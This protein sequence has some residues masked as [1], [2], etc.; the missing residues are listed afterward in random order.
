[1]F[2]PQTPKSTIIQKNIATRK[3]NNIF[4]FKYCLLV[5]AILFSHKLNTKSEASHKLNEYSLCCSQNN[6]INAKFNELSKNIQHL[7]SLIYQGSMEQ[8]HLA[9]LFIANGT[10]HQALKKFVIPASV[11]PEV[12]LLGSMENVQ[13]K[14]LILG[15]LW[16]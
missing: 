1:V 14:V 15:I 16:S 13:E 10:L 2:P 9:P 3:W 11:E 6:H 4:Y 8:Q 12:Y 5:L 7:V